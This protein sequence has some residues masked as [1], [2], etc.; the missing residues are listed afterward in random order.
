MQSMPRPPKRLA[1]IGS[2]LATPIPGKL[3]AMRRKKADNK[4]TNPGICCPHFQFVLPQIRGKS[5]LYI[6][7]HERWDHVLFAVRADADCV[8]LGYLH[9]QCFILVV[10]ILVWHS[11]GADEADTRSSETRS[12]YCTI[13]YRINLI[14][15]RDYL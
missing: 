3:H 11:V 6:R 13:S 4:T 5:T 7:Y 9:L 10:A 8:A 1:I 2:R 15:G 12:I 14:R